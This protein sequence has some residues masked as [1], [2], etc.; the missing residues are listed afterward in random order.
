MDAINTANAP[1]SVVF[2]RRARPGAE[3]ALGEVVER[4]LA[5]MRRAPGYLGAIT[6]RPEPGQT[7]VYTTVAHFA[8]ASDLEAWTASEARLNL[9]AEAEAVSVGGLHMQQ[10]TGLEAWFKMPGQPVVVPPPR[11]KMAI[12]TWLAIL[13]LLL[14]AN[15]LAPV[16]L[17]PLPP[18]ARIV[19]LSM[20]VVALM[21]WLVMPRMT[22]WF[23]F[24]LFPHTRMPRS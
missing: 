15:L 21:T 17:G 12:V 22:G 24:W 5:D 10:A 23:R 7:P 14:G 13:P 9:V 3:A 11:Y 4:I 20:L 19:P 18:L 2:S 8:S 16:L 6:L 1:E